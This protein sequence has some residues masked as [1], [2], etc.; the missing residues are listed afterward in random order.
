M[1]N[2]TS[3]PANAHA[4]EPC[5]MVAVRAADAAFYAECLEPLG[6]AYFEL[7]AGGCGGGGD[8]AA[9]WKAL[10]GRIDAAIQAALHAPAPP[11]FDAIG[12]RRR[13][14]D[15]L[16]RFWDDVRAKAIA[17][18]RRVDVPA[19]VLDDGED[20]ATACGCLFGLRT[21]PIGGIAENALSWLLYRPL[22]GVGGPGRAMLRAN[23]RELIDALRRGELRPRGIVGGGDPVLR[24]PWE[25]VREL[26]RGARC[27]VGTTHAQQTDST[28][29][30]ERYVALSL[31]VYALYDAGGEVQEP[32][33]APLT[34]VLAVAPVGPAVAHRTPRTLHHAL[35]CCQWGLPFL[36]CGPGRQKHMR[37]PAHT[38]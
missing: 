4:P 28:P 33:G 7:I 19:T 27:T 23:M 21:C 3:A 11:E 36:L 32:R 30:A 12:H 8:E 17:V 13:R 16:Y 20:G 29:T 24:V 26:T 5:E 1:G 37:V 2:A 25:A 34:L 18:Q 15:A 6:R 14:L 9:A 38:E 35:R 22:R 10:C 31:P